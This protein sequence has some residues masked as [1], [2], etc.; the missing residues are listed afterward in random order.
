MHGCG[1][2]VHGVFAR[3]WGCV[4]GCVCARFLLYSQM[5]EPHGGGDSVHPCTFQ[6]ILSTQQE[7]S[8]RLNE[9]MTISM[10]A[11]P[12]LL[13]GLVFQVASFI[14]TLI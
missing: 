2:C 4:H 13:N 14:N 6:I 10:L 7:L 11:F 1:V 12:Q 8:K 3:V 5:R 9:R